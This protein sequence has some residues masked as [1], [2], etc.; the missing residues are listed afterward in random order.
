M[1]SKEEAK[2][3]KEQLMQQIDSSFPPERKDEAK[4]QIQSMDE[5]QLEN[6]LKQNKM[7][8]EGSQNPT[9]SGGK[10]IFCS[11]VFGDIPSSKVDENS[12]AV[13]VLEI[14]PVSKGHTIIIPKEHVSE[15]KS[16]PKPAF[17]LAEEVAKKLKKL[18]PKKIDIGPS[19]M[20]G[21]YILNVI[22]VYENE[23]LDSQRH[24][25]SKE[26]LE[27][28]QK[29]LAGKTPSKKQVTQKPRTQ[30]LKSEN[31]WLPKRIP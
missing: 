26:E 3:I 18:K 19:T 22:P 17:T 10:C 14:N 25:A 15:E 13:A 21:H 8:Q 23:T 31:L 20:F 1:I 2:S 29:T 24:Q 9:G 28:L 30:K 16:I 11:I 6:F 27:E 7:I 4:K 12:K 5:S